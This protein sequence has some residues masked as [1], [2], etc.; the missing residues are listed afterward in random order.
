MK[1]LTSEITKKKNININMKNLI[2]QHAK[3]FLGKSSYHRLE[4]TG[5]SL[6]QPKNK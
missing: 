5:T 1:L 4:M 6:L 3:D 2:T